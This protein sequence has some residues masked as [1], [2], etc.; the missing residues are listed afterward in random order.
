MD[1]IIEC[2]DVM[3]S[4]QDQKFLTKTKMSPEF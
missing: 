1:K 3:A 2:W 4:N